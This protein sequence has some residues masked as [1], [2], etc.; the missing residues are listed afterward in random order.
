MLAREKIDSMRAWTSGRLHSVATGS[1]DISLDN[2]KSSRWKAYIVFTLYTSV[3]RPM[4]YCYLYFYASNWGSCKQYCMYT[5]VQ[6]ANRWQHCKP[7]GNTIW[8]SLTLLPHI[9][10]AVIFDWLWCMSS[11]LLIDYFVSFQ[12]QYSAAFESCLWPSERL[13]FCIACFIIFWLFLEMAGIATY[14]SM[15]TYLS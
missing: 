12:L 4:A 14:S 10:P 8:T 3:W 1:F 7:I 2:L 11:T 15:P 9:A 6:Y 13:V 5:I